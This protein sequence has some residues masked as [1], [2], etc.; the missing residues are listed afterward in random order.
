MKVGQIRNAAEEKLEERV[1][2]WK[3]KK[4][5]AY[6]KRRMKMRRLARSSSDPDSDL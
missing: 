4:A 3:P 6:L 2:K 1:S 5:E